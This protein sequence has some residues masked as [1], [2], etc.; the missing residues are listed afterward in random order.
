[1]KS[2]KDKFLR[3]EFLTMSVNGALGRSNTYIESASEADKNRVRNALRKKLDDISRAY[4]S[5]ASDEAHLS[6]ISEL[7]SELSTKF[8][9]CL[10]KG[11]F[12][13][14]ISQKALNLYL[15]YLWCVNAIS[16][17]PHC[18]FDSIVISHLPD[19]GHLKWT[20]IDDIKD[21]QALV[22]AAQKKANGM[23]LPEWELMIWTS[24]VQSARERVDNKSSVQSAL[25][26]VDNQSSSKIQTKSNNNISR[27]T[28]TSARFHDD[29]KNAMQSHQG[30]ELET[31]DIRK[32]IKKEPT[33]AHNVQLI[34]PSDHCINHTN[35]GACSC[36]QTDGAIFMRLRKGLYRI[37]NI[38]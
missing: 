29:L 32:L 2:Q 13:I 38:V 4:S 30:R 37:R 6:N 31:S 7:S 35:K 17:P 22:E 10:K 18:P 28:T 27:W 14:G 8:S 5:P 20:S 1:M 3:N 12:R 24:G 9:H 36:A 16:L 23:P 15:K 25:E 33:L 19:C 11:R 21:Y 26:H 34:Y